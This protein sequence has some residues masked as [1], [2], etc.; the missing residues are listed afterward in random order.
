MSTISK[1]H[2]K[3]LQQIYYNEAMYLGRDRL[4]HYVTK[5]Y[6][7]DHP[8]RQQ[9]MQWLKEQ[10]VHQIHTRPP[11]R[12]PTKSVVVSKINNYYQCDLTGPLP[13]DSGYNYIFGLIDVATKELFTAPLKNKTALETSKALARII[14]EN[15]LQISVI[16]SDNGSEFSGEFSV[17]T[18]ANRIKQIFSQASSP[19]TNGNIERH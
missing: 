15:K 16:Q 1:K 18:K 3:L 14:D 12:L 2:A 9:V 17:F 13:R 5:E 4:F 19:W 6:P 7:N 10:K 11:P 8:T